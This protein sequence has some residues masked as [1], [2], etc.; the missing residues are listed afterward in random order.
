MPGR[1]KKASWSPK[2]TASDGVAAQRGLKDGDVIL[3][4]GGKTVSRPSDVSAALA[5]APKRKA[6]RPLLLRVEI[7]RQH[8]LSSAARNRTG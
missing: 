8:A 4:A 2:S 3:E 6:A 1:G 7:G 5:A